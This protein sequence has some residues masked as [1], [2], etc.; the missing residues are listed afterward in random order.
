MGDVVVVLGGGTHSKTNPEFWN[1]TVPWVC[2][3]EM[4]QREIYDSIDRITEAAVDNSS[5]KLISPGAV[6]VVVRGMILAHT[7]PT[8][9]LH[10]PAT[11]NQDMKALIPKNGLLPKYLCAVLWGLN[12]DI[13]ALVERSGHD[14]RKLVTEKLMDFRLPIPSVDQQQNIFAVLERLQMRLVTSRQIQTD[15]TVELD[16]MLPSVLDKAFSGNL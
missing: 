11:I 4:K 7:F 8:A 2:P 13:V 12:S 1:G 3:R 16:T 14:T 9:V 6:L 5:A 10:V 15:V